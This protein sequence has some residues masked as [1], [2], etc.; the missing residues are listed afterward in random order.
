M[1]I[2]KFDMF[3]LMAT[4]IAVISMSFT[5]PALGL[6]GNQQNASDIPE[7]NISKGAA[8]FAREEPEY[9]GAPSE[10]TLRY[11]NGSKT[12]E[13][14]RQVDL[15][16]GDPRYTLSFFDR[17]A[18]GNKPIWHINLIKFNGSGSY[19]NDVDI[20]ESE[21]KELCAVD[22]AYCVGLT[23]L[24]VIDNTTG[25][26][27]AEIDWQINSQPSDQNWLGRLP[28][29]GGIISAGNQLASIVGW[30]VSIVF[31]YVI[32][33]MTVIANVLLI[34]YNIIT[35]V[36]TFI[37]WLSTTYGAIVSGA[38]AAWVSVIVAIPGILLS[39]V[40]MK[41]IAVGI[42]LLPLT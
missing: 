30:G 14:N 17:S 42:S 32:F 3:I 41:L 8:D 11:V 26:E 13:D 5:F 37:V 22:N 25:N 33:I 10:G 4:S 23:N 18:N 31:H 29:V 40:F 28:I 34:F 38:P 2:N 19:T 1:N 21:S 39:L 9:P 27:T 24:N 36:I 6:T 12:W 15:Q 16:K 7:F 35:F 20:N